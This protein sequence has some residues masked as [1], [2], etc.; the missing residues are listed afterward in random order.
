M[1]K[2]TPLS[3]PLLPVW[4]QRT[5]ARGSHRLFQQD[6]VFACPAQMLAIP[7]TSPS[8]DTG[9]GKGQAPLGTASSWPQNLDLAFLCEPTSWEHLTSARHFAVLKEEIAWVAVATCGP[10]PSCHLSP[11]SGLRGHV[12][13]APVSSH[14][15]AGKRRGDRGSAGVGGNG[16]NKQEAWA[17]LDPSPGPNWNGALNIAASGPPL[18]WRLHLGRDVAGG[19]TGAGEG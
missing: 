17:S 12:L 6:L 4:N 10:T 19:D 18:P 15:W 14:V 1:E 2:S 3:E 16:A 7:G 11:C 5:G 13:M 8:V 9:L